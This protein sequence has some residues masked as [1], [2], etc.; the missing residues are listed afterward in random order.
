MALLLACASAVRVADRRNT[1][2]EDHKQ[3]LDLTNFMPICDNSLVAETCAAFAGEAGVDSVTAKGIAESLVVTEASASAFLLK[4]GLDE[5]EAP[6]T[7]LCLQVVESLPKERL[8]PASKVG[9][10]VSGNDRI[11]DMDLSPRGLAA[12]ALTADTHR[13]IPVNSTDDR[14]PRPWVVQ[15]PQV[16]VKEPHDASFSELQE[17][18]ANWFGI[19]LVLEETATIQGPSIQAN[20]GPRE[21]SGC[22]GNGGARNQRDIDRLTLAYLV[23][24]EQQ[25][26]R[27]CS[28]LM[29]K[30]FGT[31]SNSFKNEI[32][33]GLQF[34]S[35]T[36][37][38]VF[39]VNWE[40]YP[41]YW[42]WVYPGEKVNGKLVVHLGKTYFGA[43][44]ADQVGT[45]TH[46]VA[47]H[48]PLR[49]R[50]VAHR[51]RN[52]PAQYCDVPGCLG[53]AKQDPAQA[54]L[55]DD[56]WSFFIDD[57]VGQ[58]MNNNAGNPSK[59]RR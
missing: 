23:E 33:G 16:P 52:G 53:L 36:V 48:P 49:R 34:I 20:C 29:Q 37:K 51:R 46:E 11:C 10:H 25:V 3:A 1:G 41:G 13:F 9:C 17:D 12:V 8:P 58:G 7:D 4:L 31:S 45:V 15:K 22:S 40:N 43:K 42:G 44:I 18:I 55:N 14:G 2:A 50:D 28:N 30:W 19:W 32:L 56:N 21:G 57:I 38:K 35:N 5:Q 39:Y 24:T 47:H 27:G 6:C 26:R 59:C 54:Q